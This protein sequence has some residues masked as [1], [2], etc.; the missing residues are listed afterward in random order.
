MLSSGQYEWDF[1]NTEQPQPPQPTYELVSTV[2]GKPKPRVM[3]PQT[4]KAVRYEKNEKNEDVKVET[5]FKVPFP[6]KKGCK[7]CSGR[8]YVGFDTFSKELLICKKCFPMM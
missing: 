6:P 5:E 1:M 2:V 8:G 7:R 4:L 3:G